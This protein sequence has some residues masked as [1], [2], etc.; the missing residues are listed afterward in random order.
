MLC[1]LSA[2][3]LAGCLYSTHHFHTG[4]ILP[5]GKSRTTLGIGRQPLWVCRGYAEE[6]EG[7]RAH[8]CG[9]S[10]GE[11]VSRSETAKGSVNFSLGLKDRLGPF[12]GAEMEAHLEG[13]TNPATMEFALNLALPARPSLHHKLGAGWGTGAWADNSFFL[14]YAASRDYGR[15][16]FFGNLRLTWL[17]TQMGEVLG[18]DFASALPSRRHWVGQA[19]AGLSMGLPDWPVAPDF[20]IPYLS[21]T[22]PQLPSGEGKFR[23]RDI[24]L[25]QW[26]MNFAFGWAL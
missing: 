12:P 22:L 15:P 18:E 1:L 19:G 26:D 8:A 6:P 14:E 11:S 17:A 24:P 16:V 21:V 4:M 7:A 5:A 23:A 2:W 25:A 9:D 13:P 20:L 10:A 3:M